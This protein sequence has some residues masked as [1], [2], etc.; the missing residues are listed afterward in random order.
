MGLNPAELASI[1]VETLATVPDG[2]RWQAEAAALR[3]HR[4]TYNEMIPATLEVKREKWAAYQRTYRKSYLD[5]NP[6]KAQSK[7]DK[8]RARIA[9]K[10]AASKDV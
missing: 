9:A 7:R 10:R 2:E 4:P 8:D 1:R 3:E 5:A 6:A